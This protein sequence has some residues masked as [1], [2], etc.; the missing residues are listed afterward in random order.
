MERRWYCV[1]ERC[2][3]RVHRRTRDLRLVAR[4]L[5]WNH[6]GVLSTFGIGP[7]VFGVGEFTFARFHIWMT[8]SALARFLDVS[9]AR[10]TQILNRLRQ[11]SA[12]PYPI[13]TASPDDSQQSCVGYQGHRC[14]NDHT[15]IED[16]VTGIPVCKRGHHES[17]RCGGLVA[18]ASSS[19]VRIRFNSCGDRPR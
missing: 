13:P 19:R 15:E 14:S 5:L 10:V 1:C 4:F 16:P 11:A 12:P 6:G 8:P 9:R 18:F 3:P 2:E 17:P 7:C